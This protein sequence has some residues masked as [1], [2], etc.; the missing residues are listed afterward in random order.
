VGA[1][2]DGD[3]GV[4]VP[5]PASAGGFVTGAAGLLS[6]RVSRGELSSSVIANLKLLR[7]MTTT[8]APTSSER[9]LEVMPDPPVSGGA[10]YMEI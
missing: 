10:G 9:I 4:S 8:L 3:G 2:I 5:G 7:T 6:L 1:I